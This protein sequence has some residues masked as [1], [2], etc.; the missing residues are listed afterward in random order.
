MVHI[1]PICTAAPGWGGL[2]CRVALSSKVVFTSLRGRVV[3]FGGTHI[4]GR[5]G[6][7]RRYS[8][9]SQAGWCKVVLTSLGGGVVKAWSSLHCSASLT[10]SKSML[11]LFACA[12]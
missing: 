12:E 7:V 1:G 10:S 9:L 6:G 11:F 2:W 8:H 3:E 4:S 5:Q